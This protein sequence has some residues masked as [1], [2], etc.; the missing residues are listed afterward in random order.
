[1]YYGPLTFGDRNP[2]K[3]WLQRRRLVSA[4]RLAI[5]S[6]PTAEVLCDFGAGNGELCKLLAQHYPTA[7]LVC[8][9]P[10]GNLLAEARHN[11]A[12]LSH[13]EFHQELQALPPASVDMVLCL[14]V[15]EH[16]PPDETRIALQRIH[17]LLKPG[18]TAIIGVPV[19][20]GIPALY[21]GLFRISR[22]YGAFDAN[23][24]NVARAVALHPP[25]QRPVSELGPG[26]R[27]YQDHMGFDF[28]QLERLLGRQFKPD[29]AGDSVVTHAGAWLMPEVYFVE[30]KA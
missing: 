17:D 23:L 19:E 5:R 8:F 25:R 7:R 11:L 6:G 24:K 29:A 26:L 9:E 14:E 20:I 30:R 12:A 22:R 15:F 1:M 13:V 10:T 18:G 16:L 2:I 3:R 21:K 4:V 28:R 27:Y